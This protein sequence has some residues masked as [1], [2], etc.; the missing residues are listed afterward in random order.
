VLSESSIPVC[1][2]PWLDYAKKLITK[3][4]LIDIDHYGMWPF[5]LNLPNAVRQIDGLVREKAEE[6]LR[7]ATRLPHK[8]P[9]L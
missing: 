7:C 3:Q 5:R 9:I 6:D 2:G 8:S 1:H 4:L